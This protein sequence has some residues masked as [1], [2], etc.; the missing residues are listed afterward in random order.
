V[1]DD[2][3]AFVVRYVALTGLAV[4]RMLRWIGM[5]RDKFYDWRERCG[6]PNAHNAWVP[7]D[8]WLEDWEKQ[9]I[10]DFY[11]QHP[12]EGYRRLTYMMLDRDIVAVSPSSTYRVLTE[13]GVL[14]CH[15]R[16]PSKSPCN[17]MNTGI[18]TCPI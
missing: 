18:L 16:A 6:Q 11:H 4:A 5:R 1:R 7:R 15:T 2:V 13:A 8:F 10:V 12:L 9:A 17:R 14:H 3:V